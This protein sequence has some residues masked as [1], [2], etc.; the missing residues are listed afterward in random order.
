MWQGNFECS[1]CL[2]HTGLLAT[3]PERFRWQLKF[4]F[5]LKRL[6]FLLQGFVVLAV[7]HADGTAST[8]QL[9]GK[10]GTRFYGGWL[11]EDERLAQTRCPCVTPPF[12][13]RPT[14]G[15]LLGLQCPPFH[16]HFRHACVGYIG[17][18]AS[19][20]ATADILPQYCPYIWLNL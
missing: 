15:G 12:L 5:F 11:S 9:A 8:V 17:R 10:Q 14:V 7:E 19:S 16:L 2:Y 20:V 18:M 6:H 3:I 1:G 13:C 4:L